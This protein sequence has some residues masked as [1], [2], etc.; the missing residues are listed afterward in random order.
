MA[1]NST[2]YEVR[3]Q[4]DFNTLSNRLRLRLAGLLISIATVIARIE[5]NVTSE[6]VEKSDE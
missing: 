5:F 4:T 1:K 3:L 6:I 2:R